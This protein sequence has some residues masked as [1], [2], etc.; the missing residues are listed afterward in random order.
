MEWR[1]AVQGGVSSR[2]GSRAREAR[3]CSIVVVT[4]WSGPGGRSGKCLVLG[5]NAG[6]GWDSFRSAMGFNA[7]LGVGWWRRSLK[8]LRTCVS[9]SLEIFLAVGHS[10]AFRIRVLASRSIGK[11]YREI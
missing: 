5:R 11:D 2:Q 7:V 6:L 3:S 9:F 4:L 10:R 8:F 1:L